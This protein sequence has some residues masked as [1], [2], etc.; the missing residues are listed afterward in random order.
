MSSLNETNQSVP[1]DVKTN[2]K[3]HMNCPLCN[4]FVCGAIHQLKYHLNQCFQ[5]KKKDISHPIE[6]KKLCDLFETLKLE[7]I[8]D[9]FLKIEIKCPICKDRCSRTLDE[10]EL[11]LS[12]CLNT[13]LKE[14]D[15]FS[16]I[17]ET[18]EYK[19]LVD[20]KTKIVEIEYEI[21]RTK[22]NLKQ[23][24]DLATGC[25]KGYYCKRIGELCAELRIANVVFR[26]AELEMKK[27]EDIVELSQKLEYV[28]IK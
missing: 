20:S 16:H 17:S 6:W 2:L 22:R 28:K 7:E 10:H 13:I 15:R 4:F 19:N 21:D 23:S 8:S 26:M 27:I 11:H 24:D 3:V 12:C 18:N 9:I 14:Q 1:N 5:K 25:D